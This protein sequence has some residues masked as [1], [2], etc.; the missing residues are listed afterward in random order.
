MIKMNDK[1]IEVLEKKKEKSDNQ[2][3]K[4]CE[5]AKRIFDISHDL[6]KPKGW[7]FKK[8]PQCGKSLKRVIVPIRIFFT[9]K[10][11]Y[12]KCG[13]EYAKMY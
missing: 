5:R 6:T 13:Y 1:E 9:I 2:I 8:C 11:Y 3:Q 12:C 10:Y 7:M 4:F